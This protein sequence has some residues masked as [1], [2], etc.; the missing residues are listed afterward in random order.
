MNNNRQYTPEEAY[1]M[2]LKEASSQTPGNVNTQGQSYTPEEAYN[3]ML[4][5]Q[6]NG[7]VPGAVPTVNDEVM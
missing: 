7:N 4:M 3:M 2:M 1:E 6:Q 5:E